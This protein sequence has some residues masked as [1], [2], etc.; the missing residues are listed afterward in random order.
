[1]RVLLSAFACAPH[2]GSEPGVG[3]HWALEVARLGHDVLVLTRTSNRAAIE[4]ELT[5]GRLPAGLRFEFVMR[6]WLCRLADRGLPLQLVHLAWQAIAYR[7]AR[8]LAAAEPFDLVHHIT[9]CV[10]R[11]PSFMGRLPVPF[12]LGPVGGG[13]RAPW[14]LRSGM[15]ARGWWLEL[16][17]DGLNLIARVDPIT[18]HALAA[19]RLVYVSSRDTARLVPERHQAK[20]RIGLQVGIAPAAELPEADTPAGEAT[21]ERPLRMLFVGR[22]LAWK[23]MH[24]G[25]E[26]LAKLLARGRWARLTVAGTG[27]AEAR[28]RAQAQ[29]LGVHD[30]IDWL[31]LVEH[32]RMT[33]VYR[34]HD[35]LLFPSLHDSG[36]QAVLEALV[37]GRPVVCLDLGGPGSMVDA[38]CG[39][40]VGTRGRHRRE[41]V[42]GLADALQELA[43]APEL[44]RELGQGARARAARYAWPDQVAAVY[45]EI[46][47]TL[48]SEGAPARA[49]D[50]S[51]R[52]G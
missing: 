40:V 1:M 21:G 13:E 31:G 5:G 15:G 18:R 39:R 30:A 11:Q 41:V 25:L 19:A 2:S 38:S 23:G 36:G 22:C 9:Y 46:E 32:G 45:A 34:A 51:A 52:A 7:H 6:G 47:R 42:R 50:R 20:V 49:P 17:R 33:E 35:L 16:V 24:I 27:P 48:R 8:R 44:R 29:R 26:A 12:V 37:H 3:W 4:A 43:D 14:A 28:W 10:I